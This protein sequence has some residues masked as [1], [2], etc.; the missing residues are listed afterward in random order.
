MLWDKHRRPDPSYMY[1]VAESELT[2]ARKILVHA[3][4]SG[5]RS[6]LDRSQIHAQI[7]AK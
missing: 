2:H 6:H 1:L 5:V 7:D 4:K 3:F